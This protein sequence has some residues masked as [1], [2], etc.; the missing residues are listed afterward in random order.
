MDKISVIV[1]VYNAEKY[2]EKCIE[3]VLN[4]D[5]KNIELILVNDGSLDNSLKIMKEFEKKNPKIIKVYTQKNQGEGA[6]RN[7]GIEKATGDYFVF[8]DSDDWLKKDHLTNLYKK[9][10]NNDIVISGFERYANDYT[11]QYGK[12]PI[13]CGWSKFKYCSVAGKMYRSKFIK[14][15]NLKYKKFKIGADCYFSI[16]AYS[17]TDKV[18]VCEYAGYCNYEN[19]S[20]VTNVKEFNPNNSFINVLAAIDKEIDV[21]NLEKNMISFFYLKTLVLDIFLH[22]DYVDINYLNTE[23]KN[24]ME[25]YKKAL[26]NIWKEEKKLRIYNQKGEEFKINLVINVFVLAYKL[27]CQKLLLRIVKSLKVKLI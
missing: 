7:T 2:I 11:F 10:Q 13:N 15:N 12:I 8:L 21:S 4:Q 19:L 6:A 5:Y 26:K 18:V 1:P 17:K 24:N 14:D 3:S 20:S 16:N 23:F 25:W 9:I 22:K 27:K